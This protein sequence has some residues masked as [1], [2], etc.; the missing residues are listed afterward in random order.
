MKLPTRPKTTD[1]A[2]CMGDGPASLKRSGTP[3]PCKT[4]A[5]SRVRRCVR[6]R[7]QPSSPFLTLG[8]IVLVGRETF[9]ALRVSL[10][11]Q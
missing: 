11:L 1:C 6:H 8:Q 2:P 3:R 5:R 10:G 7:E 9:L 4:S